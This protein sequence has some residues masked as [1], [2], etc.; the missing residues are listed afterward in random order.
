MTATRMSEKKQSDNAAAKSPLAWPVGLILSVLPLV[1]V[2]GVWFAYPIGIYVLIPGALIPGLIAVM[3][4]EPASARPRSKNWPKSLIVMPI[5]ATIVIY[6]VTSILFDMRTDQFTEA[7][8]IWQRYWVF[9]GAAEASLTDISKM[10][11]SREKAFHLL[12]ILLTGYSLTI[13]IMFSFCGTYIDMYI[14]SLEN[15]NADKS[16]YIKGIFGM[17]IILIIFDYLTIDNYH[18][19]FSSR[20]DEIKTDNVNV[21]GHY[22]IGIIRW[23]SSGSKVAINLHLFLNGLIY[24]LNMMFFIAIYVAY[25]SLSQGGQLSQRG[26]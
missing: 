2:A 9:P 12:F 7:S 5:I 21:Y 8:E 11:G 1:A 4:A 19:N 22:V 20:L 15:R 18:K 16:K 13:I 24:F 6:I 17:L 14:F 25:K 23:Y 26:E 10:V 3:L